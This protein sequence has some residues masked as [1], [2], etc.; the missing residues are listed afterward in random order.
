MAEY[1]NAFIA[2]YKYIYQDFMIND[3]QKIK[4]L[5]HLL[6]GNTNRFYMKNVERL[7]EHYYQALKYLE[8]EYSQV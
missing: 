8:S 5:H 1:W 4:Y 7:Y 3:K 6:T 2:E